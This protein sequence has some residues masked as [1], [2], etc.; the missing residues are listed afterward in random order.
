M[1]LKK[2]VDRR[3]EE[4]YRSQNGLETTFDGLTHLM[5]IIDRNYLVVGVN[6]AF[7]DVTGIPKENAIGMDS[8][9]FC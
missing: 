3:T 6:K 9:D 1:E 4:L 5:M 8:R 7:A 2:E